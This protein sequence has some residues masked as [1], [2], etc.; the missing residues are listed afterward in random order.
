MRTTKGLRKVDVI[1]RRIDDDFID[2]LVF[3]EDSLLGVPGLFYVHKIGNVTI[4]NSP[5]TGVADD[6]SVYAYIPDIIRYYL[7]EE[8]ILSNA[9][10][11]SARHGE[12]D[13]LSV[14][15]AMKLDGSFRTFS[16]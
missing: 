11:F 4:A 7:S 5:G 1:Y 8:P 12:R 2:P 10:P 6:K 3:R 14:G 15:C 9:D 16:A 13:R